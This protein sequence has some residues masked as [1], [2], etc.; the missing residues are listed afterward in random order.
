MSSR[1]LEERHKLGKKFGKDTSV[2]GLLSK[3]YKELLKLNNKESKNLIKKW[4][5]DLN[6]THLRRYPDVK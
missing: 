2:K 5:K 3:I 1:E 4:A 6:R